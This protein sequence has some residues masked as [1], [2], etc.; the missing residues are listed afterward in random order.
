MPSVKRLPGFIHL[1]SNQP[2][3]RR[4]TFTTN[5]SRSITKPSRTH[6]VRS[7]SPSSD[8]RPIRWSC[9]RPVPWRGSNSWLNKPRCHMVFLLARCGVLP[10]NFHMFHWIWPISILHIY[11]HTL[12]MKGSMAW[13]VLSDRVS[14]S[15]GKCAFLYILFSLSLSLSFNFRLA[16]TKLPG[17]RQDVVEGRHTWEG[18]VRQFPR[19]SQTCVYIYISKI[20]AFANCKNRVS[21]WMWQRCQRS[22]HVCYAKCRAIV[23]HHDHVWTREVDASHLSIVRAWLLKWQIRKTWR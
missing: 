7:P 11:R 18:S 8:W 13:T 6:W 10:L 19:C 5:P 16:M 2:P 15:N 9:S 20:S 4:P 14:I 23:G 17:G 12:Y 3:P 1:H 21:H 22:S